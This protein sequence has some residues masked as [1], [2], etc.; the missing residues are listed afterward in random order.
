[1][2]ELIISVRQVNWKM[3]RRWWSKLF[4]AESSVRVDWE[5]AF[6]NNLWITFLAGDPWK[7]NVVLEKS[8]KMVAIFVWTLHTLFVSSLAMP[9]MLAQIWMNWSE[10]SICVLTFKIIFWENRLVKIISTQQLTS[11][12]LKRPNFAN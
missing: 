12:S 2:Q 7:S 5:F 11:F 10:H 4:R 9:S 8:L 3:Q 1:M 6:L